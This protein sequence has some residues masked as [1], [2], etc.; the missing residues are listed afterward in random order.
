MVNVI[1]PDHV[2]DVPVVE[3]NQHDDVPVVPE[4]VLENEDEDLEEEEFEEEEEPQKEEDD[5]EVNI[6]EDENEPELTYPYEKV[7]PLN[8]SPSASESEPE[9]V[10]EVENTIEHED[11]TV[12]ANVHERDI[13]SLFG[14]MASLSRRLCGRETSH[15]LVKK[16]GKAKDEYYGKLILDLGN[17]VRSSMEQGTTA[18]EKL[19]E[20]LGSAKNKAECK[21]LKKELEEASV[22]ATERA[23]HANAGNDARGSRPVR[24]QDAAHVVRE[25]KGKHLDIKSKGNGRRPGKTEKPKALVTVD[26]EGSDTKGK[27][28]LGYRV[29]VMMAFKVIKMK[30][31]KVY[32]T[33]GQVVVE[34]SMGMIDLANV[35]GMLLFPLL[36]TSVETLE[37]VPEL[38]VVSQ[39]KVW[40][41]APIIKEYESDSDDE[42]MCASIEEQE[43]KA[44]Q[45][46][47]MEHKPYGNL[48]LVITDDFSM[49]LL[50]VLPDIIE[51]CGSKRIKREYINTKTPQRNRVAERKNMTLI[52]AARTMLADSFLPNTFWAEA[53]ST[54]C[55]V[56]N[57]LYKT[58]R[59]HVDHLEYHPEPLGKFEG[60]SDEGFLV[61]YSLNSKAFRPVRSENQANKTAGPKEA[62]HSAGTQDNIDAGNS[63]MEAKFSQDYFVLPICRSGGSSLLEEL[64]MLKRQ[65]KEANDAAE[66]L[67]KEFAQDTEDLLL[68]AGA[69]RATS[70]NTVNTAST[71]V[72]T[73]SPSG[74]LSY[75]NL[76]HTDQDDSQIPALEDIYN[77]PNDGIFTNA[78]YD[79][80][81]AVTD[82]T[83]LETIM[84]VSPIPTSRIYFIH[85]STQILRDPKSAVQIRS[86][87]NKSFRAHAFVDAMQEELLQFKIHK[88]WVLLD[89]PKGKRAIRTK[90]VYR[91][92]KDERG[93]VMDVKSAFLY[94]TID[95][96]VYVSQPLVFIDPKHPKKVYKV[97]K[98][99][100][101]LH[102]ALKAW[103]GT[104]SAFLKQSRYIRRTID[105]TLF[106][107]KDKKDIM[108][109]QVYVDDIIFGSTKKSWCDEIEALMK[110]IFQM[111]SMGELTFFLGL[112]CKAC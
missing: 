106:N 86:K 89:L 8:P 52:E 97:V 1:P 87:V 67:R 49:V 81:G 61:G 11:E 36:M 107:K 26:G 15:A 14:R 91:N 66:A 96:E 27:S 93:V 7:D 71:P 105:K 90:W 78:S 98:A 54:A 55:Y 4:P 88:V 56:L 44:T 63:K 58:L 29:Q 9:D 77:N 69:A 28:K 34:D 45:G 48:L 5:M 2:D 108:L 74:G 43:R 53:V 80:E 84:N 110:N 41:D 6:E 23:R 75:P 33:V 82:F 50:G 37:S 19:V 112:Q 68:Q 99:L 13:N 51:F 101:G 92:K 24:G 25:S 35:E 57:R 10:I 109:V 31:F 22:D 20:K 18:M 3:P 47:L 76:T 60:K 62:N 46:L 39:P 95:E 21:K 111:S 64:E 83:N 103:Y 40:S 17:E 32:L 42:Y 79:N 59:V 38:V 70:T 12:P 73:A 65:E 30:F 94:G 72:S 104:L 102:Q 85:P 16:K 100:Y